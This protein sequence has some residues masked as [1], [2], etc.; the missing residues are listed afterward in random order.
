MNRRTRT[1]TAIAAAL[2]CF[3]PL[4]AH[5]DAAADARFAAMEQRMTQL[6]DKLATSEQTI[7]EQAEL[8]KTQATPGVGA[9]GEPSELDAF[10]KTVQINGFVD[11]SYMYQFNNP[12]NPI[13]AN[14]ANQF[15]LDHNT[16]NL[17]EVLI[18]LYRPATNP[19]DAGFQVDLSFGDNGG[20][21]GLYRFNTPGSASDNFAYVKK[22]NVQYNWNDVLLKFGKFETLLGSEVMESVNNRN[23]TQG[24]LFTY[25]IPLVHT[26]LLASGKLNESVGWAA[27]VVNGWNNATDLNDNKGLLA[28][29]TYI[30]GPLSTGISSYY[31]ADGNTGFAGQTVQH[32]GTD[33]SIV[34]DWTGTFVANEMVT[35]WGNVDW[36]QQ[37]DVVYVS[38]PNIGKNIDAVWYGV[39]LGT[40]FTLNE[41]T[42]FVVRGEWLRDADGYRILVGNNTSAYSLTTTLAYKLTP[43]LLTRAELRYDGITTEG[44]TNSSF[45]PQGGAGSSTDYQGIVQVAYLF[46]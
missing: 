34:L 8:L 42:S 21:L 26:G 12:N 30:A 17:D 46:D 43:N 4:L 32:T 28:Q 16:F 13:Y 36:A 41:K 20:I 38:G 15:N 29:L 11:A 33:A 2:L 24:L 9:G 3:S 31:G 27:G 7:T 37:K 23:V 1:Q 19:G 35:F 22:M 18:E 14:A 45:F 10:L 40:Q 5:A 39:A 25:A 6:E 44:P